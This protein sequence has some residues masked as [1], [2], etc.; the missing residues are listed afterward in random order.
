M[1]DLALQPNPCGVGPGWRP[2][3]IGQLKSGEHTVQ[4]MLVPVWEED[5]EGPLA[6]VGLVSPGWRWP[7]QLRWQDP[8]EPK[9]DRGDEYSSS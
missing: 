7:R 4:S 8:C 1:G 2:Q 6:D 5:P 3:A 9:E